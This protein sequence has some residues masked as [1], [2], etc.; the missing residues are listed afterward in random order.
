MVKI[1]APELRPR[2][3][4]DVHVDLLD[5]ELAPL[6]VQFRQHRF[7]EVDGKDTALR[8]D[9]LRQRQG[10]GAGAGADVQ[11]LVTRGGMEFVGQPVGGEGEETHGRAVV[12]LGRPVENRRDAANV[13]VR[14]GITH[15]RVRAVRTLRPVFC[16]SPVMGIKYTLVYLRECTLPAASLV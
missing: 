11:Y 9:R 10:G 3:V 6:L 4:H 2:R 5:A 12:A 15:R 7:G 13:F 1:I 14:I 16:I 8:A